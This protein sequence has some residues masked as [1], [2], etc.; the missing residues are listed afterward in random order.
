MTD[1]DLPQVS[2]TRYL[3]LLK[4]RWWQVIPASI[5][6]LV[7]GAITAFLI[8]RYYVAETSFNYSGGA[9]LDRNAEQ[10]MLP[11]VLNAPAS[12]PAH[13]EDVLTELGWPQAVDEDDERRRAFV[14][15]VQS[16]VLVFVNEQKSVSN[17]VVNLKIVYADTNGERSAE[18][19]NEL[20][21]SWLDAE[22][23]RLVLRAQEELDAAHRAER[24]AEQ[25]KRNAEVELQV[26]RIKHRIDPAE[27][28]G[29]NRAPDGSPQAKQFADL[30]QTEIEIDAEIS[31]LEG[32]IKG[33]E[34][35]IANG[36]IQPKVL[37]AIDQTRDP[38]EELRYR[39]TIKK[40]KAAELEFKSKKP[41]HADY[42]SSR[43]R[44][45]DLK[46]LLEK[47]QE[48]RQ[49][50]FVTEI[51]NPA[52]LARRDEI[53][54]KRARIVGLESRLELTRAKI[55][56]LEAFLAERPEII[57]QLEQFKQSV[58]DRSE[59]LKTLQ[60]VARDKKDAFE[61]ISKAPMFRVFAEAKVPP[62]PTDPSIVLVAF[63][64]LLIGLAA[65]IGLILML[66]FLQ[67]SFKSVDDVER[68]LTVPVLGTMAHLETFE[69]RQKTT[70]SRRRLSLAAGIF[71]FLGLSVVTIYF[72]AP[73]KLPQAVTNA[74]DVLLGQ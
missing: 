41:D 61:R 18:L 74:L 4:R 6:G 73:T 60:D 37:K 32:E 24:E 67:T 21:R 57:G 19:T 22:V 38:N 70:S 15:S 47:L 53:A 64:G 26:H 33:L 8:P 17:P 48:Q 34:T 28:P 54:G 31:T 3:D 13:V 44:Y 66:D 49:T 20:R 14:K 1:L 11:V 42:D 5:V 12:V 59:T 52:Y 10:P 25:A 69:Q 46:T 65:A 23:E 45:E 9:A 72:L 40:F 16:R 7:I 68:A 36:T 71:L 30:G 43:S 2:F 56:K 29:P 58:E 50:G 55:T 27:E 63:A 35:E 51:D 39:E 62:T